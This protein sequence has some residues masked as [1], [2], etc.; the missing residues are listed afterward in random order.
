MKLEAVKRLKWFEFY[1]H[2]QLYEEKQAKEEQRRTK[3]K[4]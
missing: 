3:S 1:M 2:L 4:K